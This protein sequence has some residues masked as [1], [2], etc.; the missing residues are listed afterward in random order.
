[1]KQ[2]VHYGLPYDVFVY[3]RQRESYIKRPQLSELKE[4]YDSRNGYKKLDSY[5]KII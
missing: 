3:L 2:L 1:M 4:L 5:N